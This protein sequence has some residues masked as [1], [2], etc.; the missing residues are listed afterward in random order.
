[1]WDR[2]GAITH[3][4][5]GECLTLG[6][7]AIAPGAAPY[8]TNNGTLQSELWAGPLSSGKAVAVLFNKAASAETLS[9]DWDALGVGLR[10]GAALPVRDVYAR[11]DL[12]AATQLSA[13]VQPHGVRVFV[14]G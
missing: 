8:V 11:E 9:Y 2:L 12:G 13:L 1:V 4:G 6:L 3:G 7:P 5:S 14:V 10:A